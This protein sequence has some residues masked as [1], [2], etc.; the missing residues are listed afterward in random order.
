M[1]A[2]EVMLELRPIHPDDYFKP[3]DSQM[4]WVRTKVPLGI[5]N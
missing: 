3:R 1:L 4:F 5:I 2:D